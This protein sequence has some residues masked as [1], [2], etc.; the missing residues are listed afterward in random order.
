MTPRTK[1]DLV[2]L[3]STFSVLLAAW[4]LFAGPPDAYSLAAGSISSAILAF[5]TFRF[6]LEDHEAGVRHLIPNPLLLLLYL[7]YL[8]YRIYAA[9]FVLAFDMIAGRMDPRVV[10]FRTL[11]RSDLA[12]AV[13]CSSITLTPGTIAILIDEDHLL[14]HWV[15]AESSHSHRA[16]REIAESMERLLGRI[17]S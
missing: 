11:L 2:R 17:W 15:T 14:V 5:L 10:H 12:R 1:W 8:L 9:S 3:A 13:L 6:F 16:R 7:P 4:L